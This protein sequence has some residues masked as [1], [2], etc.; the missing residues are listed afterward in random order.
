MAGLR[1][2]QFKKLYVTPR[3]DVIK[4]FFIPA[5]KNCDCYDRATGFFTSY[6]LIE[7]SVGVCDLAKRG[8]KMRVITSPR[9][10]LEDINAIKE[11]YDRK[12]IIGKAMVASFDNP[13]D[14]S[15][16]DRLALLSELIAKG[17]LEIK[18]AVMRNLEDYPDSMFHP[19]IGIMYDLEDNRIAF[20][21]S[22]NATR[23]GL[24]GN[25]DHISVSPAK[26]ECYDDIEEIA[27]LFNN[28]WDG[29]D[30]TAET[31]ELPQIV[32]DLI[33]HYH[34][35]DSKMDIDDILLEKYGLKPEKES[36]F[37]KSP[38]WLNRNPRK[39]QEDAVD[40][41]V[42][43]D[44]R[45]IF[46]M[47]TGTG[48]TKTALRAL[49]R[50]YNN[51][52]DEGIFTIIVA[53]Q[54]HLVDQWADEIRAFG[55]N[56]IV[57]HSN[58]GG[59]W[60][61]RFGRQMVLYTL[62]PRNACL[63][64]TISSFSSKEIQDWVKQIKNLALVIDE[65]HNMGSSN[66]LSK[67]PDNARYRLALSATIERYKDSLG[68]EELKNYF[69]EKCIEFPIE[70]AIGKYLTNYYYHPVICHYNESEYSKFIESNER[71]DE[72][73]KSSATKRE[74]MAAKNEY[75][76]YSYTLNARMESK[77]S[78]LE[79]LMKDY[80]HDDHFLVY[81]GKVK[82]DE[83]GNFV[84]SSH[85]EFVHAI[86]K[87][88]AILGMNGL[89]M[90]ISRITYRE[91]AQDRKR[92]IGE[93]NRGET[94]GI[95]AISCLDEGVDIPSI[96]T[97]V[98]MSSSDNP[99]EYIQRRGRVLRLYEGKKYAEI[100]DFIVI[101]KPLDAVVPNSR[102]SGLEL[103]MIAKEI[104]RMVEFASVSLNSEETNSLLNEISKSYEL[105]I[106]EIIE[107]YGE[108]S[109]DQY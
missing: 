67:L 99:R 46:D 43:H 66:R 60:K 44:Y 100:Y 2:L 91:S 14:E 70:D 56:P 93:F 13:D 53:P 26:P 62:N 90:K 51:K 97:A 28:L 32:Q 80:I 11:G 30:P 78:N 50:L 18:I 24:G 68:T 20:T 25:W 63:V 73:L 109:D 38:D 21:G 96:K 79:N 33:D 94:Q 48:K 103:K 106:E 37:F 83:E 87:T 54:K 16:S 35:P 42:S 36:V 7:L 86:D 72:I 40:E 34:K 41:W 101:P 59:S 31:M 15:S 89:G 10:S 82:T 5:L 8:G 22:M 81:S 92:I 98:I 19:K 74:K 47:A 49:E 55:V 52:P 61:E 95:V 58:V 104:R 64:T 76:E 65:A 107:T 29:V 27:T 105:P 9:L 85:N 39:Y 75:I 69:G 1:D 4:D 88:A 84:S 23:N 45:G 57:G 71:L 108:D 77:F 102:H 6:S 3:D 12:E 17:I